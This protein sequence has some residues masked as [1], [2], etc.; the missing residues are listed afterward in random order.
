MSEKRVML[1]WSVLLVGNLTENCTDTEGLA[2]I[3]EVIV[4][5]SS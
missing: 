3:K 5:P 2:E 4:S 1:A